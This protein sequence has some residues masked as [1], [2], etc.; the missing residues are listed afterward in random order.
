MKKSLVKKIQYDI[1]RLAFQEG[2]KPSKGAYRKA[3]KFYLQGDE[4][5]RA[6]I[7]G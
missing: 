3:K 1:N 5:L 4:N 2:V 7:R 6:K